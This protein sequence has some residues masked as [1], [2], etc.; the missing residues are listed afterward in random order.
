MLA[1]IIPYY[2]RKYF[3]RTLDSLS[4]QTDNR[5]NVYIGDDASPQ[6]IGDL[7]KK[8]DGKFSFEYKRFD[9]NMGGISLVKQWERCIALSSTEP[10]IMILGDD[11]WISDN[12]VESFYNHRKEYEG[13]TKLIRFAKENIQFKEGIAKREVLQKN[14]SWESAAT[15]FY[16]RITGGTTITLSEYVFRREVFKKYKF[17]DYPKAWHSDNRAWIEFSENKPIYSINDAFVTV[18]HDENSITGNKNFETEKKQASIDFYR[19]L[20]KE[21]LDIFDKNQALRVIHKYENSLRLLN[22]IKTS[23]YFFLLPYYLKNFKLGTFKTYLKKMIKSA[24]R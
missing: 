10:W 18:V 17:Y 16:R 7:L 19:Y 8:Y 13:R 12:L 1:V 6:E 21:K 20:V 23:D 3:E 22:G 9:E 11:D 15:A 2:K 24:F 4:K 14:P 5:F